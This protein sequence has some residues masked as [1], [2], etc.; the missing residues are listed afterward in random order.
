[1]SSAG[2][3]SL[4]APGPS[5]PSAC[6]PRRANPRRAGAPA[7]RGRAGRRAL[8]DQGEH[9][10]P[11]RA[12]AAGHRGH[13]AG[14]G[15][16]RRPARG[17]AARSRR[18]VPG[19]DH[20]ARLGHAVLGPVEFPSRWR[21]TPGTRHSTRA[22]AAPA[23]LPL[24]R[25]AT[26]RCTWAPTSAARCACPRPGAAWWASSPA[27]GRIPIHPPYAGRVAGPMTR[28][29]ADAAL[30]MA[31]LSLAR[32]ARHDEPAVPGDRLGRPGPRT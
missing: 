8:H 6:W 29:V 17:A 26:G 1:M 27:S 10:H 4:H 20:D 18:G 32:R 5:S 14:A 21:A 11:G 24:R 3:R 31:V 23:P 19:Q 25:P 9:R 30:M 16:R 12:G 15:G 22:A 2:S 7:Y 28:T 13:R